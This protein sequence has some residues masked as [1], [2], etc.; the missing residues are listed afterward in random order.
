MNALF[1]IKQRLAH[2][3]EQTAAVL[4]GDRQ[5]LLILA[6]VMWAAQSLFFTDA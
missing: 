3:N 6:L 5:P 1:D 2:Q 4:P